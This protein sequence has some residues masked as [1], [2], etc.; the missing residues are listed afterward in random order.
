M[1]P[2]K[3]AI[4]QCLENRAQQYSRSLPLKT[5]NIW[6]T[7]RQEL[8]AQIMHLKRLCLE[9]SRA[10]RCPKTP[11]YSTY[12]SKNRKNCTYSIIKKWKIIHYFFKRL[13]ACSM[14]ARRADWPGQKRLTRWRTWLAADIW[15]GNWPAVSVLRRRGPR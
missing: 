4:C 14:A 6:R 5:A 2:Q 10:F 3:T 13:R 8:P 1:E 15:L 12:G 7:T 9:F 11:P